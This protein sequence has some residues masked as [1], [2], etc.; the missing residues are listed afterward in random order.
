MSIGG[1]TSSGEQRYMKAKLALRRLNSPETPRGVYHCEFHIFLHPLHL[2]F[3]GDRCGGSPKF[4]VT[5]KKIAIV[6]A[7]DSAD[8]LFSIVFFFRKGLLS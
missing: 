5:P 3:K 8:K 1:R 6:R 7:G 4:F 2:P